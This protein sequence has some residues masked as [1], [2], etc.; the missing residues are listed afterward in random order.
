[1]SVECVHYLTF[2]QIPDLY[3]SIIWCGDKILAIAMETHWVY[4]ICVR[5]VVLEKTLWT[6]VKNLDLFV[7]AAC[8]KT[9]AIRVIFDVTD[10]SSVVNKGVNE[11]GVDYIPQFNCS[12]IRPRSNHSGVEWKL[13]ASDPVL[14]S[15]KA[16]Y[17]L[18]FISIPHFYKLIIASRN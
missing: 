12:V 14:V 6:T 5:V 11:T 7:C 1:M 3:G 2:S 18:P 15:W 4:S 13:R 10:H 8:C 16:L 9:W 17:E